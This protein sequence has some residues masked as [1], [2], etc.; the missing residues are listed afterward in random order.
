[1]SNL[2]RRGAPV[3]A[4]AD[5][6]LRRTKLHAAKKWSALAPPCQARPDK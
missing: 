6:T 2:M 1:M 3:S 5:D 4:P